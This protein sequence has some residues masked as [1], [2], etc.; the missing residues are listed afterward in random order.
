MVRRALKILLGLLVVLVAVVAGVLW[1]ANTE[2]GRG[3]IVALVEDTTAAGPVAVRVTSIEGRLPDRVTVNNVTLADGQGGFARIG[4]VVLDWRPLDL[5][6]GRVGVTSVRIEDAALDRLPALP[7]DPA[8]AAA[9]PAPPSLKV[10]LPGVAAVLDRLRIDTLAL[11]PAVLGEP[12]TINADPGAALTTGEARAAGWVEAARVDGP[13]ARSD[14]DLALVPSSGVLKADV[15]I[16]EPANG[17]VATLL[18]VDGRPP[19]AVSLSGEGGLEDWRGTLEGGFGPGARVDLDLSVTADAAGYRLGVNGTVAASRL[20]PEPMRDLVGV[21][22]PVRLVAHARAD[23]GLTLDRF[24]ARL[25]ALTVA[26]TADVDPAGLPVAAT[27]AASS[28]TLSAFDALVGVPLS[29]SAAVAV[30]LDEAGRRLSVDLDGAPGVDGVAFEGLAMRLSAEAD[31][32]LA[33]LP[34]VVR[35]TIGGSVATPDVDGIDAPALIGRRLAWSADATVN[36]QT[37]DGE[38]APLSISADGITIDGTVR[39]EAGRTVAPVLRAMV[40]DLSRFSA[41]AGL[42]LTGA[43]ALDL[44][45]H[46]ELEPGSALA[47]LSLAGSGVRFGDPDLDTLIGAAP[48][49]LAG[50][51]VDLTTADRVE[52]IGLSATLA[53]AEAEGDVSLGVITGELDGRLAVRMADLAPLALVAGTDLAGRAAVSAVVAGTLDAPTASMSWRVDD[54]AIDGTRIDR[55]TGSATAAGLLEAP[56]G[57][58]AAR[59]VLRGRPL[60]LNLGYALDGSRLEASEIRVSGLDAQASGRLALDLASTLADGDLVV[61]LSDLSGVASALDLPLAGGRVTAEIAL[62]PADNQSAEIALDASD[63]ALADGTVVAR[64]RLD[65]ALSGLAAM[66]RGRVDLAVTGATVDAFQVAA[67]TVGA[68]I[69]DGTALIEAELSGE[70]GR[71]IAASLVAAVPLE[72]QSGPVS[73]RRVEVAVGDAEI[74]QDTPFTV[75]VAP[76]VRIDGLDLSVDGGRIRG[77][78]GLDP[79]RLDVQIGVRDLPA[80]LI[81]L[82][83]RERA[84]TGGFDGDLSVSGPIDNPTATVSLRTDNVSIV[85]PDAPDLPPLIADAR[86]AV[87]DRRAD[88]SLDAS[89]GEGAT[90]AIAARVQGEAG[91]AGEPPVFGEDAAFEARVDGDLDL[92][93][94]SAA[95]PID[96]LTVSGLAGVHVAAAGTMGDPE[97]SGAV[98]V[99]GGRLDVPAA[100][101]YLREVTLDAVGAAD[102][103][104]IRSLS[105]QAA[106]GGDL[107]AMGTLRV[108]PGQG[109][110]A[111]I[112][113]TAR[114][115][116]AVDLDLA[117]V[118]LDLDLALSG[119]LPEYLLAGDITV[120]PT[121]VQ[122]PDSLPPTVVELDVVEI[123]DGRI[124]STPEDAQANGQAGQGVP[125]RLDL[126][127]DLPGQIFVVGRGLDSE[128]AGALRISGLADAPVVEGEIAVRQGD[129]R[130]VGQRFDFE[131]GAVVFDG[132]P[133]DDP[134]IDMRLVT[135]V[136]DID[137][138]VVVAGRASA[139]EISLESDPA[140]PEEDILSRLLVGSDKAELTPVQALR[141]AQSAA[142]LSGRWETGTGITDQVREAIGLDTL[143]VGTETQADGSVG[144]SLSVG[145]YIAPG[146]FFKLQ[147]G[148]SGSAVVEVELDENISV[149]TDVG[150]DSQ[151]RVGVN[152]KLDY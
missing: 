75:A 19:L 56:R 76:S 146:V 139:P 51:A 33:A 49:V 30:R 42:D 3:R 121:R 127:V 6:R 36:P 108:D 11:G 82:V 44:D 34:E 96:V 98:T 78:A 28:P 111:D 118:S 140:L 100:G 83:D 88:V 22:M 65:A 79:A 15:S 13:P 86:L 18:A 53:A 93:R 97:L 94:L 74:R 61:S 71:P 125:L 151:S 90:L 20:V 116:N 37:L 66:P 141:L 103:L 117:S 35:V 10:D 126:T 38:I 72:L 124:V 24:D 123:R 144:A 5:L 106:G 12:V 134:A 43:A 130:A 7:A 17:L 46:V 16:L 50:V 47:T 25:P 135:N 148:L 81:R 105:A 145:K 137:A 107:A 114:D 80:R 142:V 104:A 48:Q 122:I 101:L 147:Q 119:A 41:L 63:M 67:M 4:R 1:L 2:W 62:D 45:A 60:D 138:A 23:G 70:A 14:L 110:P 68:E 39:A 64:T 89:I 150:A 32:P 131:R 59:A 152:Y 57:A 40:P 58:V 85:V 21:P 115:F 102:T 132:G 29:G 95:L 149:E 128:W 133:P 109:F 9:A 31:A 69:R 120:L 8:P 112:T 113:L 55:V 52:V 84:V 54:L 87:A 99:E 73:V 91:A 129:F 27:V 26:A 77:H 143:D 136:T 92:G